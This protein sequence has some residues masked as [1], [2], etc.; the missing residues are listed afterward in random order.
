MMPY[1]GKVTKR[2]YASMGFG[3]HGMNTALAIVLAEF[4]LEISD[5]VSIFKNI[6]FSWN[7][8]RLG[9]YVAEGVCQIMTARDKLNYYLARNF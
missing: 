3:G 2:V 1:V 4:L 6:P 9:S 8:S 5:Q 7:G